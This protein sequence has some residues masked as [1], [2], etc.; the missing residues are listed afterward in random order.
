M[1][2]LSRKSSRNKKKKVAAF[3]SCN[4]KA[5]QA[6]L[7]RSSDIFRYRS[8]ELK[9]YLNQHLELKLIRIKMGI[10]TQNTC[11][12]RNI[13]ETISSFKIVTVNLETL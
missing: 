13:A 6:G 4:L 9:V 11:M 2:N 7:G 12:S 5:E 3:L 10:D 8:F 1:K